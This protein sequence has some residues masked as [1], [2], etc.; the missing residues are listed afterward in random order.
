MKTVLAILFSLLFAGAPT[1]FSANAAATSK[2]TK[3]CVCVKCSRNCCMAQQ[4]PSQPISSAPTRAGSQ[5]NWQLIA[6][7]VKLFLHQPAVV[8][9]KISS[10]V[11]SSP[12]MAA[13]PLYQQNCSYLI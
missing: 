10:P 1:V 4:S 12:L 5:N 3:N 9:A 11:L 2:E 7:M 8:S 6:A 13:V